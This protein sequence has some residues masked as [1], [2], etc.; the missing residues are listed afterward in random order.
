MVVDNA[1]ED[2]STGMVKEY[3]P[4]VRLIENDT[5]VGFVRANNQAATFIE[6]KYLLLLNSDTCLQDGIAV[7]QII[8]Y[9]EEHPEAGIVTA[10]LVY[11]DGTFQPPYRR[12]HNLLGTL[13]FQTIGRLSYRLVPRRRRFLCEDLDPKRPHEIDWA[14]GAYLFVRRDLL[15]GDELFDGRLFMYY[16]DTLLCLRARRSGYKVVYL[17]V[18]AVVHYR[19]KSARQIRSKAMLYSFQSSLVYI[20]TLYGPLM[21]QWYH[22][23]AKSLWKALIGMMWLAWPL[24]GERA[25]K[26][27]ELFHFLLRGSA[28]A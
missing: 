27:I 18:G 15:Q 7:Q 1:S 14:T 9:M 6:G 3:F 26:K 16:E 20:E 28:R 4:W 11:E 12:F 22:A 23:A 5:N 25:K 19:Q 21:A 8:E 10:R 17:P 24:F 2:G 13:A